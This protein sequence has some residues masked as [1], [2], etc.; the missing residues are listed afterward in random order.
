[1]ASYKTLFQEKK[2]QNWLKASVA[3][4]IARKGLIPFVTTVVT[5][6]HQAIRANVEQTN[7]LPPGTTCNSCTTPNVLPCRTRG[8]C[9]GFRSLPCKFH[10]HA[11]FRYC[12]AKICNDFMQGIEGHHRF[13]GPSW[14]NT[15]ANDW[16]SNPWEVAKCFLPPDGYL[17]VQTADDTDINGVISLIINCRFFDNYFT[18]DLSQLHNICTKVR[19][20]G[21]RLRHSPKIM[22]SEADLSNCID[23]LKI[24]LQDSKSLASNT[25]A[26]EALANLTLLE[27]DQLRVSA[28]DL[29]N[30]ISI[31][32][33]T[34]SELLKSENHLQDKMDELKELEHNIQ[35]LADEAVQRIANSE[36]ER[37]SS[38]SAAL[39]QDLEKH[40]L[41]SCSALDL[42]PMFDIKYPNLV[43]VY[44]PPQLSKST[45]SKGTSNSSIGFNSE[46]VRSEIKEL[47]EVFRNTGEQA[48][49]IYITAK[50]GV[51][52][53]LSRCEDY[54]IKFLQEI[55]NKER[56]LMIFDGLD[57]WSHP[58]VEKHLCFQEDTES[59]HERSRE[60]CVIM[61]TSRHWKLGLQKMHSEKLNNQGMY[62][63]GSWGGYGQYYNS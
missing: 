40:Y 7:G 57:E 19:D 44:I 54:D 20:V 38:K 29:A 12:P 15:N 25:S 37:Y 28:D 8:V 53:R 41:D 36:K 6:L 63:Y 2:N 16:C 3:V 58:N 17:N 1:M 51:I 33:S 34:T 52:R 59:P 61:I 22:V 5:Y 43:K 24:L 26:K 10:Q 55:L 50:A 39:K 48:K 62:N 30:V 14:K 23:A 4:D 60:K 56:C 35:T 42:G 32:I 11:H 27:N 45:V 47:D 13:N 9:G 46:L 31:A 18:D 21:R 49:R